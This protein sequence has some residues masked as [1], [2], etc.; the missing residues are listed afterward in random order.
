M[1]ISTKDKN[2]GISLIK[3]NNKVS[4]HLCTLDDNGSIGKLIKADSEFPFNMPLITKDSVRLFEFIIEINNFIDR[5]NKKVNNNEVEEE[6][7]Y[8]E[9][10]NIFKEKD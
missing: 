6:T 8:E 3:K 9:I 1:I 2:L 7:N 4:A 10:E 5:R